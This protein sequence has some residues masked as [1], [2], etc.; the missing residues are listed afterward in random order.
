[1]FPSLSSHKSI[2]SSLY[3]YSF[4]NP[5]Q[6]S[7]YLQCLY[8]LK[9]FISYQSCSRLCLV[10]CLGLELAITIFIQQSA[11]GIWVPAMS[12]LFTSTNISRKIIKQKVPKSNM[13]LINIIIIIE[14]RHCTCNDI[15]L[16]SSCA[17]AA[18]RKE[19]SCKNRHIR[20]LHELKHKELWSKLCCT[21]LLLRFSNQI[22]CHNL[23]LLP[24]RYLS[25]DTSHCTA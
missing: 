16:Q 21:L 13:H 22:M 5:H 24:I 17:W 12:L 1:M 8:C 11:S 15:N 25:C 9:Q 18:L 20:N 4:S 3:P 2:K 23:L 6:E 14:M 10:I 7:R 19:G